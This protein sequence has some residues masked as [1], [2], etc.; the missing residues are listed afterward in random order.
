MT[1]ISHALI[2]TAGIR[3]LNLH[4]QDMF[5]AYAFGVLIDIDHVIKIP[6]YFKKH[7][8]K[9]TDVF[10]KP[11][12]RE[13]YYNW[14]TPLQE[15]IALLWIVPLGI[16]INSPVPVIF[17]ILHILLDYSIGFPKLPF[18][19]FNTLKTKGIFTTIPNKIKE[20]AI[21]AISLWSVLLF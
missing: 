12:P 8:Y 14:R 19:P 21:I 10:K 1:A 6:L 9:L 3:M 5:L 13:R 20:L 4:G 17:F 18:F 15:P 2:T 7:N 16:F 11:L